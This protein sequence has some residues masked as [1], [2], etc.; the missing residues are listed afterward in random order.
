[1]LFKRENIEGPFP[2]T[3]EPSSFLF[4][5]FRFRKCMEREPSPYGEKQWSPE[6]G[7]RN[8]PWVLT[9]R[10]DIWSTLGEKRPHPHM[11]IYFCILSC[12]YFARTTCLTHRKGKET[13]I[14]QVPA[15]C[16]VLLLSL[17]SINADLSPYIVYLQ[18]A[19]QVCFWKAQGSEHWILPTSS[20][21]PADG[22]MHSWCPTHPYIHV[23]F[24]IRTSHHGRRRKSVRER[25]ILL[26]I[27]VSLLH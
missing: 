9:R 4:L 14:Y 20:T 17:Y 24:F 18:R 23:Y 1:M 16:P 25:Q 19:H 6:E 13:N 26:T 12:W 10:P 3:L 5:F 15:T 2:E 8:I 27:C 21:H 11:E 22:H 7:S